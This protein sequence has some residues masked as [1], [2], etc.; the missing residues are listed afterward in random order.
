MTPPTP[1]TAL[2]VA[3]PSPPQ[4]HRILFKAPLPWLSRPDVPFPTRRAR[5]KKKQS[6]ELSAEPVELPNIQQAVNAEIEEPLQREVAIARPESPS[7]SHPTSEQTESTNP[8]TPSSTQPP[9]IPAP[10]ETTPAT[11]KASKPAALALPIIP[12]IPK[13]LPKDASGPTSQKPSEETQKP[14]ASPTEAE[15][16]ASLDPKANFETVAEETKATPPAPKAWST[17]K[18]WSGVFI[19][20]SAATTALKSEDS[21]GNATLFG[22]PNAESLANALRSFNATSNGSKVAFLKPRGLVNTGNMC[23]MN[24]VLQVLV[25]C[26]PFYS[27]L[28]L[29]A[30][31]AVLNIKGDTPLMEAMIM[32]MQQF[33][34]VDSAISVEQLRLR[35]KNSELEQFGDAFT[36]DFVYDA[37]KRVPSFES[38]QRGHQQDAEEFLGFLLEAIHEECVRVMRGPSSNGTSAVATPTN[39][40]ASPTS[41]V[42]SIAG[43]ANGKENGWLEVLPKQKTAETRSSGT[44]TD[45]PVTKI[46]GGKQR[47]ELRVPG[48]KNSVT[49]EPY[50]PLQLDISSDKVSNITDAL[51]GLTRSEA[52][53]VKDLS[54]GPNV[55]VSAYKQVFIETLPPVLILHLKRFQYDNKGGTQKI[56][57]KVGYPLE[58]EIPKTV[59][60]PSKR[61]GH[62][63][64]GLP[65]YRLIAVVYHHG[66]NASGG[67]YTVDV[68]RQ[69]GREWIRIDDTVITPIRSE[70]VA[71]GG[72]EEKPKA[73]AVAPDA[74]KQDSPSSGNIFSAIEG[75]EEATEE[76]GWK[77]ASGPG[78]KWSSVVN[79]TSTPKKTEKFSVKDNKVAYLL[80][81]QKI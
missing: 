1:Q 53:Q 21:A 22:K 58:L 45:S 17:P 54:K 78:K 62:A 64:S 77:Q 50:K 55:N 69:D 37:M 56:W 26:L 2:S 12:A 51:E 40:P 35:L 4:E 3:A 80:F 6:T 29:V 68:R 63:L 23:Y 44:V 33:P 31:S 42:A 36:P 81:Y 25:F 41:D 15:Q 52:V 39:V 70:V 57:K 20:S 19:P 18:S 10:A 11:P 46:F 5:R 9:S 75:D 27:F 28:D 34:I 38:M 66:K 7:T 65:T 74:H 32:F 79:G 16:A 49:L 8:T 76:N 43:S 24:S 72:R 61:A 13:S 47:S 60:P 48:K 71:E 59:F 14:P 30:K 73:L 67:H